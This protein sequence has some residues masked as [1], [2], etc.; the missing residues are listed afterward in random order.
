MNNDALYNFSNKINEED[1]SLKLNIDELYE[2]KK[3]Q[4]LNVLDNYNKIL[5]RV[6]NKIKY[7]SKNIIMNYKSKTRL[8]INEDIHNF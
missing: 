3:Q 2:K 6:H 7:V 1:V 4:D 5:V 8:F